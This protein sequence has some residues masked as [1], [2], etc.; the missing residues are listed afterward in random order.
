MVQKFNQKITYNLNIGA[1]GGILDPIEFETEVE[2]WQAV[3]GG[4]IEVK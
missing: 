4:T 1:T 2:E 3:N